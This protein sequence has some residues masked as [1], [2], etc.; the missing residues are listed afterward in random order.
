MSVSR[1]VLYLLY[2]SR[3][4]TRLLFSA[5]VGQSDRPLIT[6]ST[7]KNKTKITSRRSR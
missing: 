5:K 2:F 7:G 6:D 3:Y 4:A 1:G